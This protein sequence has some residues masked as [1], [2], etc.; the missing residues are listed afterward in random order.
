MLKH[1]VITA[2]IL[3]P[4]ALAL[5]F[6]T[7]LAWFAVI[8]GG[9]TLLGAWEWSALMGVTRRRLRASY[10]LTQAAL[11]LVCAVSAACLATF[12]SVAVA[13]RLAS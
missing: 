1:R 3:A 9:I 12:C 6:L 7:P 13:V 8:A 4:V 2:L 10:L 11:M 5:V